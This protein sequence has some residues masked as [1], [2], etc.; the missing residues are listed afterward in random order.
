MV[1]KQKGGSKKRSVKKG[2]VIKER[3]MYHRKDN[4]KKKK[5]KDM[6]ECNICYETVEKTLDNSVI[7]GNVVHHICGPCKLNIEDRSCPMCRSHALSMPID[8]LHPLKIISKRGR[9][10]KDLTF[11]DNL[12]VIDSNEF[13][14]R[15]R[16]LTK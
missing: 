11:Q 16:H 5:K 9:F 6:V 3:C 2:K 4:Y 14:S 1:Q 8:V 13:C 15:S 10:G 7:C 12:E